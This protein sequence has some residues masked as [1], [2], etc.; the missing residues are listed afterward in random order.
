MIGMVMRH[1]TPMIKLDLNKL[2]NLSYVGR[3][4]YFDFI[5]DITKDVMK[6]CHLII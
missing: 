1:E 2:K 6:T 5:S 3:R 4:F